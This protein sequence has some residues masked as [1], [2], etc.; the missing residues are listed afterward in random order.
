M[1]GQPEAGTRE[2]ELNDT[3]SRARALLAAGDTEA[4]YQLLDEVC[5]SGRGD[6]ETWFVLAGI[7]AALE[8]LDEV[9]HCCRQVV[10]LKPTHARAWYNLGLANFKLKCFDEAIAAYQQA[11]T[12]EPAMPSLLGNLGAAWLEAGDLLR[13]EESCRKAIALDPN[14]VAAINTLGIVH[15]EAGRYADALTSFEQGLHIAP[16]NVDLRWNR[17]LALLKCGDFERGWDEFE[18]RWKYETAM[19]RGSPYP[20]W[21]GRHP[22]R[23]L[24][25]YMEQGIGDQIMFSSCLPDLQAAGS[26][27]IV[28]C[29]PRLL[30]LF[31][32]SF[33]G[34]R[35]YGGSWDERRPECRIP[36]QRQIPMGSLPRIFRRRR[37]TFPTRSSYLRADAALVSHWR[38][39]L[40]T[41]P[42]GPKVGISWRGG[43]DARTRAKR[44]IPLPE[45]RELC[46]DT[47]VQLIDVQY[48]DRTED[49]MQARAAGLHIHSLPGVDAMTDLDAFAALLAALDLLVTVDNSTLHLAGALGVET[50]GLLPYDSDWRWE[51]GSSTSAWYPAVHLLHQPHRDD[52]S[53]PLQAAAAALARRRTNRPAAG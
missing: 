6:A 47:S 33:P 16:N 41:L 1:N 5:R 53:T 26:E 23:P 11:L 30:P 42:A 18:W 46:T 24:L 36:I 14:A 39:T 51:A 27:A 38:A 13:A 50:L 15:R 7:C 3:E 49:L 10:A 40:A 28:E 22:A 9:V 32:R 19:Q 35:F 4:A 8:R 12:L 43:N 34:M 48:G 44:S 21:L 52:W 45:W 29:A 20:R 31:E 17:A 2:S 25:V 37:D